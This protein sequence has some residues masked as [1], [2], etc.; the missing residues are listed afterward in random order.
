MS[1]DCVTKKGHNLYTITYMEAL[2]S[3][4]ADQYL[5]AMDENIGQLV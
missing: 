2:T 5:N 1:S 3:D 4:N